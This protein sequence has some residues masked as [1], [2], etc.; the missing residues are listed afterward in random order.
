MIVVKTKYDYEFAKKFPKKA[1]NSE[2]F[3]FFEMVMIGFFQVKT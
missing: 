2:E 1:Q 3:K